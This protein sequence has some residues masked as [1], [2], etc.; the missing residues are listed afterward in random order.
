MMNFILPLRAVST[1]MG[2]SCGSRG[3]KMPWGRMATVRKSFSLSQACRTSWSTEARE[4]IRSS[5]KVVQLLQILSFQTPFSYLL[6]FDLGLCVIVNGL[7]GVRQILLPVFH[8]LTFEHHTRAAG[9]DQFL[10]GSN[11]RERDAE[12]WKSRL[13]VTHLYSGLE[14][15]LNDCACTLNVDPLEQLAVIAGGGWRGAMKDQ[16]SVPEGRQESLQQSVA[17]GSE[18][19]NTSVTMAH[20]KEIT[21]F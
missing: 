1:K 7:F 6:L 20:V 18:L 10:M 13:P 9:Q 3:P 17:G 8:I 12:L 11:H 16:W 2:T 15:R 4:E 5:T 21:F 14:A 19:V